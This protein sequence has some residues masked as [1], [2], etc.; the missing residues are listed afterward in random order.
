MLMNKMM[1]LFDPDTGSGGRDPQGDPTQEPNLPTGDNP[2]DLPKDG[3]NDGKESEKLYSKEEL[4]R[5]VSDRIKRERK[6]AFNDGKTEAQ[7]LAEMNE[8]QQEEYRIQ[9]ILDENNRLK[10]ERDQAEMMTTAND[11]LKDANINLESDLVKTFVVGKD[12]EETNKRVNS[13]IE[14]VNGIKKATKQD[15]LRG[16][17]TPKDISDPTQIN[18]GAKLSEQATDHQD[19]SVF[20]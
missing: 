10:A 7:K 2:E 11:S 3:A 6:K 12:A 14:L 18:I 19:L 20:E 13:F 5:I 4:E 8:Q 15:L 17:R 1:K 9:Q 16:N